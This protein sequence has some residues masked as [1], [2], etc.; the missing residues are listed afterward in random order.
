MLDSGWKAQQDRASCRLS[1]CGAKFPEI[2]VLCDENP[3]LAHRHLDDGVILRARVNLGHGHHVMPGGLEC[4]HQTD[5]AALVSQEAHSRLWLDQDPVL[6][7]RRVC[8]IHDGGMNI[9]I[10]QMRV[11]LEQVAGGGAFAEFSENE[12]QRNARAA[13][14]GLAQHHLRVDLDPALRRTKWIDP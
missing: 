2:M 5:V 6:M 7:R 9:V 10:G 4:P 12:L 11:G 1:G 8:G 14:D 13:H 3:P